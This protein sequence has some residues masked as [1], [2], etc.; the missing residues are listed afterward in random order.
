MIP[1]FKN[2]KV[3]CIGEV[4]WDH[5][6]DGVMPG[7]ALLNI[8]HHLH[9]N[10]IPVTLVSKVGMD[11]KGISLLGYMKETGLNTEAIYFDDSLPTSEVEIYIDRYKN[12]RYHIGEPVAWDNL[13][14]NIRI[15]DHAGIA[16]AIV[17]SSLASRNIVTR[18]TINV[19]LNFDIVKIMTVNLRPPY[20]NK[21][22]VEP[23]L[24]KADIVKLNENE[25]AQILGWHNKVFIHE[26]DQLKWFL[27][28][29]DCNIICV[30]K[31]NN[32][33][34]IFTKNTMYSHPGYDIKT[35]NKVGTGAAFLAGFISS[36][37]SE[38]NI[39]QSLDEA[40]AASALI[41][42]SKSAMT[43]NYQRDINRIYPNF[44]KVKIIS[45]N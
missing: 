20:D 43:E 44:N 13:K 26:K 37:I 38:K 22:V 14:I 7:G 29:Y 5:L 18:D 36:L 21:E 23:L 15:I 24:L 33:A 41:A 1:K 10:N 40:C 27:E 2:K 19:L 17:Y 16:G 30:T 39:Q 32:G 12:V 35:I 3:L 42:A 9:K 6:P 8:A 4:L 11:T 25:L 28:Y 34:N 31:R 45:I